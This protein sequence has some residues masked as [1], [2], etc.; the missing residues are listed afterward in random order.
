M[1]SLLSSI[2]IPPMQCQV[3]GCNYSTSL[4]I[5]TVDHQLEALKL[6]IYMVH[7]INMAQN[8]TVKPNTISR[9]RYSKALAV[10]CSYLMPVCQYVKSKQCPAFLGFVHILCGAVAFVLMISMYDHGKKIDW[11]KVSFWASIVFTATGSSSIGFAI[12]NKRGLMI[13]TKALSTLSLI[14]GI[15]VIICAERGLS[16]S[17]STNGGY[18]GT[19]R[20]RSDLSRISYEEIENR[21]EVL[22]IITGCLEI[23]AS[24]A[25]LLCSNSIDQKEL[26]KDT[27]EV[28]EQYQTLVDKNSSDANSTELLKMRV[29]PLKIIGY[30][31]ILCGA[32]AAIQSIFDDNLYFLIPL[33]PVFA[34]GYLCIIGSTNSGKVQCKMIT[35]QIMSIL[36]M[37]FL[38]FLVFP[39]LC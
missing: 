23:I 30:G 29:N 31:H 9:T 11:M 33:L 27:V 16:S 7:H 38:L 20:W 14:A 34:T 37:L 8:Y 19:W 26:M 2:P 12:F 3:E 36:S 5:N 18:E 25:S 39:F 21:M 4:H 15:V 28:K 1:A 35:T 10:N 24:I 22:L 17:P 32:V 6:H 13:T